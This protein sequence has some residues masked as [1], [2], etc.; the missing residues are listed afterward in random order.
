MRKIILVLLMVI[1]SVA[2]AQGASAADLPVKAPIAPVAPA[3]Y[4]WT[5]F[6]AG[7]N[8]GGA[9]GRSDASTT[10][11]YSPFGWFNITSPPAVNAAGR[12]HIHSSGFTG[13]GQVGYNWQS[14]P[15]VFGAEADIQYLHL[16]GN[17]RSSAV[18][19]C[20]SPTVFNVTSSV[21]TNWLFTARPR[22]GYAVNNWLFYVTGGVAV[23]DLKGDFTFT[24]NCAANPGCGGPNSNAHEAVSLTK[25][26][27]GWTV[28]GGIEAALWGQ[29]SV[30]AEY[31]FLDFGSISGT[32]FLNPPVGGSNNNP[33]THT[34]NLKANV[35]RV[36]LN[37]HF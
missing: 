1:I 28:G 5:G 35:A 14:G 24:D 29:W 7:L 19:P 11:A 23:T 27:A 22:L 6:Y 31:L 15:V 3:A 25:T 13:G 8:L 12:Q 37:Y 30:K 36:G 2:S 10:L 18:Y 16:S 26:R 33:F 21:D 9:W 17:A 20:C 32:G 34:I 4:N